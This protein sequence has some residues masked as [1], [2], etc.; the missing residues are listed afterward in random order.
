MTM[1]DEVKRLTPSPET[2]REIFLKSGN[3]CA[4][5]DCRELMM[6]EKGVFIGQICHIEAASP[7]GQRFNIKMSNEDRRAV[8]NLMLM[9]YKHHKVTDDVLNYSVSILKRMKADHESRFSHPDRAILST[10]TDY[11]Q[12]KEPTVVKNLRR[13]NKVLGWRY[14]DDELLTTVDELNRH[15]LYF[16][17]IPIDQRHLV[18]QIAQRINLMSATNVVQGQTILID[19]LER[20]FQISSIQL[21]ARLK[22]LDAYG[23]ANITEIDSGYGVNAALE[24]NELSSGWQFWSDLVDFCEKSSESMNSFT[25][26]LDFARL[27]E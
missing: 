6:D 27:D 4:F 7:G 13:M 11:T 2:L 24:L 15:I 12:T 14:S 19:D 9:C 21:A 23:I 26:E 3:L 5:P 10:L 17:N 20:A 8:S 16:R 18:G 25:H 22:A 1:Q